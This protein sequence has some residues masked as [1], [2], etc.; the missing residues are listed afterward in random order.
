MKKLVYLGQ[1]I[2][3]L[4]KMLMYEYHY[5]YMQPAFGSMLNGLRQLCLQD[6]D[7]CED[8]AGYIDTWFDASNYSKDSGRP[9]SSGKNRKVNGM[10]KYNL[11]GL[12]IT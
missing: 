7:F 2:L 8:I 9:I 11:G 1:V 4:N 6:R 10:M 3:D 12:I 5:E